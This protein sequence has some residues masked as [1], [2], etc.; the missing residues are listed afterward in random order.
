[1]NDIILTPLDGRKSFYDKCEVREHAEKKG[2]FYL[3]SFNTYVASFN[4]E[5]KEMRV[6]GWYSATTA[7]HINAFLVHFGFPTATKKQ[8]QEWDTFHTPSP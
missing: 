7:R 8:M 6:F 5:T 3:K 4:T 1:M 2:L